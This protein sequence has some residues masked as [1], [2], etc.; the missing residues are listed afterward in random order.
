MLGTT[1]VLAT[2]FIRKYMRG[3]TTSEVRNS[4]GQMAKDAATTYEERASEVP[5]G[6]RLCPSASLPVPT[7]TSMIRG[8]F[9]QS[10]RAEWEVDKPIDAGFACLHFSMMQPQ[11]Y[12]YRY[13]ATPTSFLAGGRGDLNGDGRLSDFTAKGAVVDSHLVVEPSISMTDPEE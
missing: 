4:L 8:R 2:F 6:R 3:S 9:Y 10:T 1:G 12:Q 5:P 13:E 11:Y 7:A